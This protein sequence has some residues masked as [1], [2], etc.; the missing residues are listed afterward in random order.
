MKSMHFK[1]LIPVEAIFDSSGGG[2]NLVGCDSVT[3]ACGRARE[4]LM[5]RLF[6]IAHWE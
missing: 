5:G 4:F 6:E 2:V 3:Y 1:A